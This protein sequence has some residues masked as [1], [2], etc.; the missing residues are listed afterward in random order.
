[1]LE[2]INIAVVDD[3]SIVRN[4]L[5]SLISCCEEIKVTM[6]AENGRD[7]LNQ[8]EKSAR[9]PNIVILD[10]NMPE[11]DGFATTLILKK[12]YPK[13][14]IIGLSMFDQ[15]LTAIT[16]LKN[17]ANGY[18]T[19]SCSFQELADA[20]H[21]VYE[22]GYYYSRL[23]SKKAFKMAREN[24]PR[25]FLSEKE[26][27]FLKLVCNEKLSYEKIAEVLFVSPNTVYDYHKKLA[28]RLEL[29]SRL[30]LAIF[31]IHTGIYQQLP[32]NR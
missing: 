28:D 11:L 2:L 10:I 12:N 18:L 26:I 25:S 17:G 29:H 3:H 21:S 6:Q 22:E 7:F 13:I 31:A 30:G 23:A 19:K 24:R 32:S 9:L 27:E 15:E 1:M 20:I 4:G 8:L 16:L 5:V 14:K